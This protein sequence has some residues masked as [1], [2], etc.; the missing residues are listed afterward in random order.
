MTSDAGENIFEPEEWIDSDSLAVSHEATHSCGGPA[1]FITTK[2]NP[3][4]AAYCYAAEARSVALLSIE[5][6]P[7]SR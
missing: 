1:A 3:V 2:E 5:R 7:S 6:S 4:I